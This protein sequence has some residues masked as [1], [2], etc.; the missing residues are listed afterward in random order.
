LANAAPL[1]P[2]APPLPGAAPIPN[3]A[4]L[5]PG[6]PIPVP[7]MAAPP[8]PN[9]NVGKVTVPPPFLQ[10][11]ANKKNLVPKPRKK[12]VPFHWKP[13][14]KV[15]TNNNQKSI[16]NDISLEHIQID[17]E[18]EKKSKKKKKIDDDEKKE[19]INLNID[20]LEELFGK[21][22]KK[23]SKKKKKQSSD[24]QKTK[25]PKREIISL[26][27]GK[28]SY[29]M[30]IALSRLKMKNNIIRDSILSLNEEYLDLDKIQKLMPIV[31]NN[32]EQEMFKNWDG[33]YE[34]LEDADKFCYTLRNIENLDERL[35]FWEFKLLFAE[36]CGDER[37]KVDIYKKAH[38]TVFESKSFQKMLQF[39]LVV[40]NYMN[41]GTKKGG[42]SGFNVE[43]L[44]ALKNNKSADKTESLL[45][46]I[47]KQVKKY[48]PL[49][50]EFRT[51]FIK[52]LPPAIKLDAELI[53]TAIDEIGKTLNNL[54]E[55]IKGNMED[56]KMVEEFVVVSKND[57]DEKKKDESDE[58][59][60][61]M[62][63]TVMS[64]FWESANKQ[65]K[66]LQ[67]DFVSSQKL[68]NE[69]GVYLGQKN[70]TEYEYMAHLLEFAQNVEKV[71]VDIKKKEMEAQKIQKREEAKQRRK[72]EK[73]L[74][75][76][77]RKQNVGKNNKDKKERKGS[78]NK[79]QAL[80]DDAFQNKMETKSAAE[81][82]ENKLE[83]LF[84]GNAALNIDDA[85]KSKKSSKRS[86]HRHLQKHSLSKR[87]KEKQQKQKQKMDDLSFADDMLA[88]LSIDNIQKRRK[89]RYFGDAEVEKEVARNKKKKKQQ[90]P[91]D[92]VGISELIREPTITRQT[93][94]FKIKKADKKK[95]KKKKYKFGDVTRG[96]LKKLG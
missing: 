52:M 57:D 79:F 73:K 13:I 78:K 59:I 49:A 7:T 93:T 3:A 18:S 89:S 12:M 41:S 84:A 83:H 11:K 60:E 64:T 75:E 33:D 80:A 92:L 8:I 54:Y 36:L 39:I 70:D 35:K 45:S 81:S 56:K 21:P 50:L 47:I 9:G 95:R 69:L 55:I 88:L 72:E 85:L 20:E 86:K 76:E 90:T 68:M 96:V 16:W 63:D 66:K 23:K 26:L 2:L 65:Y 28:R 44:L 19:H 24:K 37:K 51:N 38:D 32:E 4:P 30:C 31:P 1:P 15:Q 71:V 74:R 53:K 27:D 77:K 5:P 43:S 58:P 62:F 14:K 91:H 29:N 40:G 6:A 67:T 10:V 22:D 82:L 94:A 25:K 34:D 61:D 87:D 42:V 46:F 48:N 17:I